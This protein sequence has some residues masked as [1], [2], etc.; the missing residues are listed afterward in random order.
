MQS[1]FDSLWGAIKAGLIA[2]FVA[3]APFLVDRIAITV[4]GD[5]PVVLSGCIPGLVMTLIFLYV[6][7][8]RGIDLM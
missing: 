1:P 7:R 3:I 6:V 4:N 2:C 8:K 5:S